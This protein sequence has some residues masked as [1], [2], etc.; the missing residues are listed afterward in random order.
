MKGQAE[1]VCR[2]RRNLAR[3]LQDND[4]VINTLEALV[5]A[6]MHVL[7]AFWYAWI[8]GTDVGHLIISLSSM[9]VACAFVFGNSLRTI[10][11]SV[12]F[13]FIIRP[14]QVRRSCGVLACD[15]MLQLHA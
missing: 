1:C 6:T 9:G 3:T 14:Y 10:Y 8:F 2:E 11:E 7:A 12:V 15:I 5:G 4:E 13:L